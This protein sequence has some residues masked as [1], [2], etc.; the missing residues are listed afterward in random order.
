VVN[1]SIWLAETAQGL[2]LVRSVDGRLVLDQPTAPV[3]RTELAP[4]AEFPTDFAARCGW[5]EV[6]GRTALLTQYPEQYFGEP[7]LL[8]C[9]D[10]TVVRMYPYDE[11]L[12]IGEDATRLHLPTL[13]RS[14]RYVEH[15]V[16]SV[17]GTVIMPAAQGPHAV[18]IQVHGAAIHQ[19][20][21]NRLFAQP[22]L[23]AG[24]AMFIYDKVPGATI[25]TQADA[26]SEAMD[27]LADFPGI[28][29]ARIGLAGFSNGMWS[30]PMVAARRSDVAFVAGIGAPGVSQG[31]S[32]TH[33]RVKIL[34][35][36]GVSEATLAAVAE[37]WRLI[38]TMVGTGVPTDSQ[39]SELEALQARLGDVSDLDRYQAPEYVRNNPRLHPVPPLLPASE[40]IGTLS[41][42]PD[43]EVSYDP[44]PDY[45]RVRCPVFL[46]Y[47]Q[48]DTSVPVDQ[49]VE[50]LTE[51]LA[52]AAVPHAIRVYPNLEHMLN[53]IPPGLP[54]QLLETS[55][56]GFHRFRF[57]PGVRRHLTQWLGE[58]VSRST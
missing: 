56:A 50:R 28:D 4:V 42:Q 35:D 54:A 20:D 5:Y 21:F 1:P 55:I 31:Q 38:F 51:A 41:G 45:E 10:D 12:L 40:L 2:V 39:P 49:S 46:Q 58:N 25:F 6:D 57:G 48:S 9:R 24:I 47:G 17:H 15:E 52:R 16:P 33:R 44:V 27:A 29:P 13:K 37:A 34:R 23:D 14:A 19:R 22:Y 7:M 8:L 43:P 3:M 26:A 11:T 18:A 30:V 32:E 53:V 36:A